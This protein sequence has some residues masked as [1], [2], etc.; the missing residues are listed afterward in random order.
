MIVDA[1]IGISKV[2]SFLANF[3]FKGSEF[4]SFIIGNI[5]IRLMTMR[6]FYSCGKPC[7]TGT[8]NETAKNLALSP[9]FDRSNHDRTTAVALFSGHCWERKCD[10]NHVE[11]TFNQRNFV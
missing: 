2:R 11:Q 8:H 10:K 7:S 4:M 3:F 1:C 5:G 9:A 6:P